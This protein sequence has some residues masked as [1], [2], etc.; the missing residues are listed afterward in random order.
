MSE[1]EEQQFLFQVQE[2]TVNFASSRP[3][4]LDEVNSLAAAVG[5]MNHEDD[6][7]ANVTSSSNSGDGSRRD[8]EKEEAA[9]NVANRDQATRGQANHSSRRNSALE[10]VFGMKVLLS[11]CI[12]MIIYCLPDP[13]LAH[14]AR[15]RRPD[16]VQ[17]AVVSVGGGGRGLVRVDD[18][19]DV[20]EDAEEGEEVV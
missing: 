17:N 12:E 15:P 4:P 18:G 19:S 2:N 5:D 3:D 20:G 11:S 1:R 16:I 13:H 7:V 9:A 8:E 10:G 6:V 14:G